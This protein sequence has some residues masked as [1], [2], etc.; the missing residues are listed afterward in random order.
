MGS[1]LQ[2]RKSV[3]FRTEVE[4][5][6]LM[7]LITSVMM[8]FSTGSPTSSKHDAVQQGGAPETS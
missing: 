5:G 1:L 3:N 6:N 4:F 8:Y 2:F 7:L